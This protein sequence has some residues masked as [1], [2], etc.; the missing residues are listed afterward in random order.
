MTDRPAR[1]ES[2]A[3]NVSDFNE[4]E[5]IARIQQRLAPPPDWLLVGIGDDAAVVEPERNR[6]EVLTTDALVDGVHFNRAFV[7]PDAIGY[8]ALAVNLSDLAAMGAAPRLALLSLALPVNLP[9]AD[10][11]GIITGCTTLACAQRVHIVG[12]NLT[13]T[14]GPLTIDIT[15]IG[16]VKRRQV[17]TRSGARAGDELFVTGAIGTAAVGLA[18][19]EDNPAAVNECTARYL[20][21]EPRVRAGTLLG[22]NR[23]ASACID[24]SDGFADA[25]RQMAAASGVGAHV[26]SAALPIE[27]AVR[28]WFRT[29]G[30]DPVA[31]A[32]AGGDDYELLVAVRPRLRRQ[33]TAVMRQVDVAF[34]RVGTCTPS[35]EVMLDGQSMPM[36]YGPSISMIHLTKALVRRWLDSLL[37]VAD[38]PERTAAAFALGVF[39]G[40]SPFLGLHTILGLSFAFLLNLNRV[41]V[42]L[43]VYANLPWIIAPYYVLATNVG[44]FITG[45]RIPP[46][47]ARQLAGLFELS[48][49]SGEF[50]HEL[51]QILRP[52]LWPYA[53]GSLLGAVVLCA[54]AY[55][56]A[57]AF[58]ASERRL[59]HRHK[60]T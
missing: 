48:L 39:F 34:T 60:K 8:R 44:A 18:M 27:P 14:P 4:R 1:D 10:F 2:R 20:R 40:F 26:D 29:R 3:A 37:H 5:L 30:V 58:V 25:A 6:V 43:G 21:P 45:D 35:L 47:F 28:D 49:L 16:A 9:I 55:P 50:W 41:A 33:L 51:V 54:V 38:T 32:V 23:L 15:A 12:G 42:L 24:L 22:R 59:S 7:P 52:L 13:H 53:A 19:L 56:I 46:G 57:L 31:A 17:L 11:D 36:G